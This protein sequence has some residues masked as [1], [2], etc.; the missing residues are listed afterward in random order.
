MLYHLDFHVEYPEDMTQREL[1]AIWSEEADAA[2]QAKSAGIVV[3]LWKCVGT[4]RVIVIVDVPTPDT[5]D[6][7]LLDLPIMK[8]N[9]HKVQVEVTPLRRYEDFA[10]DIKARLE[11]V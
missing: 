6:Q 10:A 8:K 1:F 4:R 5:L 7:I 9:G 2:L 3:D 11:V